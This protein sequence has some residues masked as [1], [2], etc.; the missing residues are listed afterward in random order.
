MSNGTISITATLLNVL[1]AAAEAGIDSR[2][3]DSMDTGADRADRN[4]WER[5]AEEW[6]HAT[7]EAQSLIDAG[8]HA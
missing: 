5:D 6:K 8:E 1:L 3:Q 2:E 7:Q 4:Q